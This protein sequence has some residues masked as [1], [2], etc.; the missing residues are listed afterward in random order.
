MARMNGMVKGIHALAP[1]AKSGTKKKV[2]G[3]DVEAPIYSQY[4]KGL[5]GDALKKAMAQYEIDNYAFKNPDAAEKEGEKF[6]TAQYKNHD[7]E[8]DGKFPYPVKPETQS[9]SEFQFPNPKF[10]K[11]EDILSVEPNDGSYTK[12]YSDSGSK[13]IQAIKTEDAK[14]TKTDAGTVLGIAQA[15]MGLAG[16]MNS[17]NNPIES[18]MPE[19]K[20]SPVIQNDINTL[21]AKRDK[22]LDDAVRTSVMNSIEDERTTN[23]GLAKELSGGSNV[24]AFNRAILANSNATE[25]KTKVAAMDQEQRDKNLSASME[26]NKM[27]SS[28]ERTIYEDKMKKKLLDQDNWEKKQNAWGTLLNAGITNVIGAS[29]LKKENENLKALREKVA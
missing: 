1:N 25:K 11:P 3:G 20:I 19:Y 29:Q 21:A 12:K 26:G 16:V 6:L 17:G 13:M 15:G 22:G 14:K 9:D 23:V 8:K 27:L 5:K 18:G 24:T 4:I 2:T 10:D 7:F 28:I